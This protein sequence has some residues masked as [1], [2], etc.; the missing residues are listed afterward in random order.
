[1]KPKQNRA[2]D[3]TKS[4]TFD[5]CNTPAYALDPL[6]PY[7]QPSWTIWEP[8]AGTGTL[9]QALHSHVQVIGSELR[10]DHVGKDVIVRNAPQ[11]LAWQ[12]R[13][14]SG[15][16]AVL[17]T[18]PCTTCIRTPHPSIPR[19]VATCAFVGATCLF[20]YFCWD[21]N[22][23]MHRRNDMAPV[24]VMRTCNADLTSY[25]GFQWPESGHVAAPDWNPVPECGNG[26]HGLL[27]G[28]GNAQLLSWDEDAKWLVVA[29]DEESIVHLDDKV[30]FLEGEVVYCGNRTGAAMMIAADPRAAGKPIICGTATAGYKGTATAGD[31]GTATAGEYGTATAG[32][33]GTATAGDAGTATAGEYGTATAGYKGTAAGGYEGTAAAG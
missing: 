12:Q 27:W 8:A 24:L 19:S 13:T 22:Q 1:M 7:I 4:N 18:S 17:A 14:I 32:E 29:V 30:K 15:A 2:G 16:M 3:A 23:Y 10:T 6:L 28:C 33:Y 5:R 25:G 26:L 9:L 20:R 21:K 11:G 31:A